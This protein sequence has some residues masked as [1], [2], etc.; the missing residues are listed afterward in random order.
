M[1]SS[2]EVSGVKAV[3]QHLSTLNDPRVAGRCRYELKSV[4]MTGILGVLCGAEGWL[5]LGAFARSKY[6][7][8]KTFLVYPEQPPKEGVFRRVFCSLRAETFEACFRALAAALAGAVNGK[9]VAFDGKA[10]RGALRHAFANT[11]LHQVHAW[12]GEQRLLLARESVE[13][14]SNEGEAIRKILCALHLEGAIVTMDAG[15]ACKETASTIIESKADYVVTVKSNRR[16]LHT[17]LRETFAAIREA[18]PGSAKVRYHR[19]MDQGHGRTEVREFW[20]APASLLGTLSSYWSG[21]RTLVMTRRTRVHGDGREQSWVHYYA[22]SLK[23]TVQVH[24]KVVREHWSVENGLHWVLDVQMREDD[25]PIHN[26]NGAVNFAA[27]RRF[28]LSLLQRNKTVRQG[29]RSKQKE[30]GWN[31]DY[32][33]HLFTLVTTEN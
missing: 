8:L 10:L 1:K 4:L 17:A 31:N 20:V 2:K 9:V 16:R 6:E 33:L 19:T 30:A 3:L 29:T 24:A 26:A 18:T 11:A 7:W 23:P 28:A 32:L 13:G 27:L 25:C 22:S 15:N 12:A 21:L 14:A 5:D